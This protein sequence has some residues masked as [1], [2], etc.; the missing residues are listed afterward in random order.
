MAD[1]T[2]DDLYNMSAQDFGRHADAYAK[3]KASRTLVDRLEADD[4]LPR[5]YWHLKGVRES[6]DY[7]LQRHRSTLEVELDPVKR[8]DIHKDMISMLSFAIGLTQS[9]SH[10]AWL[11]DELNNSEPIDD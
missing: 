5:L 10:V 7:Q 4:V 11:F 2:I 8:L 3:G 9:F 6:V 1:P